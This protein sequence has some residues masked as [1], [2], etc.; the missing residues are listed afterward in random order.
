VRGKKPKTEA[1]AIDAFACNE[2]RLLIAM[3]AYQ[4]MQVARRAM[5]R[6]TKTPWSLSR[7]R[8]RVL[9]FSSSPPG[10]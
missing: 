8:E 2:V 9:R 5:T 7:L 3:I 10:A 1:P 4:K 6:A